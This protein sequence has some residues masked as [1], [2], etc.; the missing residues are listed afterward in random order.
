MYNICDTINICSYCVMCD[1]SLGVEVGH[2]VG[3][4]F[5]R[6]FVMRSLKMQLWLFKYALI[7]WLDIFCMMHIM[8]RKDMIPWNQ[9][10]SLSLSV[11]CMKPKI[12]Y[13]IR[14]GGKQIQIL[15]GY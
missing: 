8:Y 7:D 9:Y 10:C 3:V 13:T 5:M 14:K 1:C 6:Y 12:S 2:L 15:D 11:S 4:G